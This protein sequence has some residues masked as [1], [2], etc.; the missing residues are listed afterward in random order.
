MRR[1]DWQVD[2]MIESSFG[3]QWDTL[4]SAFD[5]SLKVG[6][7]I[8]TWFNHNTFILRQGSSLCTVRST[9]GDYTMQGVTASL[10]ITF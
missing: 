6:W 4:G 9:L 7:E 2:Q 1:N 5:L 8:Q 3:I 10:K